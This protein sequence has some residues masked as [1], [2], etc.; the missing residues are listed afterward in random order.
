MI[1]LLSDNAQQELSNEMR[2]MFQEA[3]YKIANDQQKQYFNQKEA[4]NYLN[5][6]LDFFRKKLIPEGIS[7]IQ[8]AG[9]IRYSRSDLDDFAAQHLIKR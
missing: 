4:A 6:S 8:Y 3:V 9:L 2:V 7:T 5:V 1:D